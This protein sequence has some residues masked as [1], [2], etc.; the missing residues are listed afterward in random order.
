MTRPSDILQGQV[1]AEVIAEDGNA[2]P[3][4]SSNLDDAY[5][6]GLAEDLT[7]SF[8]AGPA[9][10]WSSTITYDPQA[11]TFD[12]EVERGQGRRP[13]RDRRHRLRGVS[14]IL[15]T[16]V[17]QGIGPQDIPMYGVDGNMGNPLGEHFD[18]GK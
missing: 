12:S 14:R 18:A 13:R 9:A 6:N 3:R 7:A 4:A 5:G 16:M 8:E 11:Q 15:A 10:R 2:T 17:E 1:L